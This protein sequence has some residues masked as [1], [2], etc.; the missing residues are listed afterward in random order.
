MDA[1]FRLD[2]KTALVT[3]AG[4]GI[5]AA[6]ARAFA[7]AGAQVA[8]NDRDAAPAEAVAAGLPGAVALPGDVSDEAA[9]T[10]IFDALAQRFGRLD[11]LVNNAGTTR[12]E[13]IFETTLE[14]WN[15]ILRVNLTSA[16][17]CSKRA[18]AMMRD[19][20][21]QQGGGRIILL[22]SVTGHQGAL[23]GHLHYAVAKAG[24]HG[25]AKTLARTG[26]PL[27]ITV[28]A[29]APGI[30]ATELLVQT[31]GAEG[32]ADLEKRVPLG[33]GQPDDVAAAALYLA[34]DAGRHVTGAVLDVNGGMY[35]R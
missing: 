6:I 7:S 29:I 15:E 34:S 26:A 21:P 2:G 28:N 14:S 10:R 3:G 24:L 35:M 12:D 4:R 30:I 17:L 31:H 13:T 20:R 27:G 19:Q 1:S 33:L 23:F 11:V 25:F 18:M 5:G 8:V 32:V 9:V 16:F 22:G